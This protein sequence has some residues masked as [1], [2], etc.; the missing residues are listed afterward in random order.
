MKLIGIQ[1]N[2]LRLGIFQ[3]RSDSFA[4]N[5]NGIVR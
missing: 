3:Q 1:S 2:S 4:V 5:E